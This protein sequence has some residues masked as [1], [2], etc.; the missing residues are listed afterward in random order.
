MSQLHQSV[1]L[2]GTPRRA[3]SGDSILH[4]DRLEA[5]NIGSAL[6]DIV[7]KSVAATARPVDAENGLSLSEYHRVRRVDIL[8]D[9][10]GLCVAE[11]AGCKGYDAPESVA[12]RD[13]EAVAE[14]SINPT[15]LFIPLKDAGLHEQFFGDSFALA[16]FHKQL[17][18]LRGESYAAG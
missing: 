10:I 18:V 5:Q 8:S 2:C 3:E 12:D 9:I 16:V 4:A 11:I 7:E 13:N 1:E 17:A 14:Q 6:D 15:A